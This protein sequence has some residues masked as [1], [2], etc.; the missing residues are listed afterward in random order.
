MLHASLC[1]INPCC[2][3]VKLEGMPAD[4]SSSRCWNCIGKQRKHEQA[5]GLDCRLDAFIMRAMTNGRAR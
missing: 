2:V 4:N 3:G 1:F 5:E